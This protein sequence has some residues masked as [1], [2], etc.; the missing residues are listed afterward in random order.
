MDREIG[1]LFVADSQQDAAAKTAK[2]IP[3]NKETFPIFA[4]PAASN[5]NCS[6]SSLGRASDF[7]FALD[8]SLTFAMPTN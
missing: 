3:T 5:F 7:A 1:S 2:P 4:S 6:P 8:G